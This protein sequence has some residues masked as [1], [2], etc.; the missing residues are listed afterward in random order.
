MTNEQRDKICKLNCLYYAEL[1]LNALFSIKENDKKLARKIVNKFPDKNYESEFSECLEMTVDF[2]K[3]TVDNY[4]SALKNYLKIREET[5][6]IIN[7]I[8]NDE[9]SSILR[10]HYIEHKTWE[11]IAE[12]MYY[13]L[14]TVKYKHKTALDK[15]KL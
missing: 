8:D 6:I 14:R 2:Y 1:K 9:L 7:S 13:S 5:E 12:N 4:I 10:Y 3:K 11:K 15:I